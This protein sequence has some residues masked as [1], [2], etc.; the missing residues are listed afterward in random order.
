MVLDSRLSLEA[1]LGIVLARDM[2]GKRQKSSLYAILLVWER[3]SLTG[4]VKD[5]HIAGEMLGDKGRMGKGRAM[6]GQTSELMLRMDLSYKAL[7]CLSPWKSELP[8]AVS[9]PLSLSI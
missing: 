7:D 9:H 4:Q 2:I 3:R 6:D 1:Q 8:F 5:R